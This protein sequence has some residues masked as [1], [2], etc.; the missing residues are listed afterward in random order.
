MPVCPTRRSSVWMRSLRT[1]WRMLV[2]H[3]RLLE[4]TPSGERGSHGRHAHDLARL[5]RDDVDRARSRRR[6]GALSGAVDAGRAGRGRA[7]PAALVRLA[8]DRLVD[9]PAA[10]R[11]AQRRLTADQTRFPA[12]SPA[13]PGPSSRPS[14]ARTITGCRRTT[15]RSIR[16]PCVAHRTSPTNMGLALLANLAAY[17]FGYISAGQLVE[18]TAERPAHDGA[19]ERHRGPLLQLVRHA[20]AAAA[21]AAL[22]LHG[23]QRQPG[24]PSAD[25]AAGT[26]RAARSTGSWGRACSTGLGDTLGLLVDAA[27]RTPAAP[28]AHRLQRLWRLPATRPATL[29]AAQRWLRPAGD[30]CCGGGR[31]LAGRRAESAPPLRRESKR[32]G[33]A[34]ALARQCRDALDDWRCWRRGP[35]AARRSTGFVDLPA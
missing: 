2:T 22:H 12:T 13:G 14:S 31:Q 6:R 7:D 26:A 1:V 16:L 21:A 5:L 24:R 32:S 28:V 3:R 33:W 10:R 27:R 4:W 34:Q 23:G 18:R 29:A 15:T 17:D 8:R 19:L 11:A 9:Q 20:D 30:V 35:A 25:L